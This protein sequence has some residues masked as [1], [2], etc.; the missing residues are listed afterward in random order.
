MFQLVAQLVRL[1]WRGRAR[2]A[3][4]RTSARVV[5]IRVDR[6]IVSSFQRREAHEKRRFV[7]DRRE[8]NKTPA[9]RCRGEKGQGEL[10]LRPSLTERLPAPVATLSLNVSAYSRLPRGFLGFAHVRRFC[11]YQ[12]LWGTS[13]GNA[14]PVPR[15][16]DRDTEL[17]IENAQRFTSTI[18]QFPPS[19]LYRTGTRNAP[20]RRRETPTTTRTLSRSVECV[21]YPTS[22]MTV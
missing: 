7:R 4:P 10:P 18:S 3:R 16:L 21:D 22:D 1:A 6:F 19:S 14:T 17:D 11:G 12:E 13:V 15:D 2:L 8:G 5:G 20:K 9:R